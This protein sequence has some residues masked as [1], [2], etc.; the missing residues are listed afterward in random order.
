[1]FFFYFDENDAIIFKN[2]FG[3]GFFNLPLKWDGKDFLKTIKDYQLEYYKQINVFSPELS[4]SILEIQNHIYSAIGAYLNG[5]PH[6]A[7]EK[8]DELLK[9]YFSKFTIDEK[10]NEYMYR[11]LKVPENI[12]YERDR[13]FHIPFSLRNTISTNRYSIAGYP[14]LYLSSNLSLCAEEIK[15]NPFEYY[16]ISSKYKITSNKNYKVVLLD[17]SVRPQDLLLCNKKESDIIFSRKYSHTNYLLCFPLIMACSFVRTNKNNPFAPEYIVP[18]LVLQWIRNAIT[19]YNEKNVVGIKYFSC[20]TINAS[21]SGYNIVFPTYMKK[22]KKDYCVVL[23]EVLKLT[24]PVL[25]NDFANLEE[26]ESHIN[27]LKEYKRAM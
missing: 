15:Y 17:L 4:E 9:K 13:I 11:M 22:E 26:A 14:C 6:I 19:S 7:Y 8:I 12:E 25:I 10:Y 23:N 24:K 20:S 2:I 16:Y 3:G 5:N 1:M 21:K 18:Q 27:N